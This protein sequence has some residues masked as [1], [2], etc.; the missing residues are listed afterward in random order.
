ME[1]E[2]RDNRQKEWFWLDNEYLNGYAKLLGTTCTVVYLSLC[3][4]ANNSTQSCFPMIRTIAE[5]NGIGSNNTVIRA[6][7]KLEEWNII[8]VQ[9]SRNKLTNKQNPN[10]YTL[11][12][13]NVWNKKPSAI[14]AHGKLGA[15]LSKSRVSPVHRNY[16]HIN[17]TIV[18]F[19]IKNT[20]T[21]ELSNKDFKT[22]ADAYHYLKLKSND[23]EEFMTDLKVIKVKTAINIPNFDAK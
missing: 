22:E 9:R 16:T 2:I 17:N 14:D 12:S 13:K 7:K 5:E 6:V 4:H 1:L 20:K 10:I 8:S 21:K 15:V 11:L 18:S 23:W 19:K 3:R